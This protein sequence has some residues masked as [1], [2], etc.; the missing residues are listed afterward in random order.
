MFDQKGA[1]PILVLL[2]ALGIQIFFA[3]SSTF[4]FKSSLFGSLFPK[5]ASNAQSTK[6]S[7]ARDFRDNLVLADGK[8]DV[9]HAAW[10]KQ[11]APDEYG[12]LLKNNQIENPQEV[13]KIVPDKKVVLPLVRPLLV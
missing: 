3:T 1:V 2:A 10:L 12:S 9:E 13:S 8:L 11:V 5:P 6:A 4:N 7:S